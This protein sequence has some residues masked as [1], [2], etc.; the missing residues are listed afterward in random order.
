M[1]LH[2]SIEEVSLHFSPIWYDANHMTQ[3]YD[4]TQYDMT[5]HD[6]TEGPRLPSTIRTKLTLGQVTK[7][8]FGI[9]C[10]KEFVSSFISFFL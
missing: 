10:L 7:A 9:E 2:F 5:Q 1:Y 4:M 8:L 6:M 3:W